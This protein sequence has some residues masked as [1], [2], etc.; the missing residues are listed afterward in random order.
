MKRCFIFFLFFII[1]HST[2]GQVSLGSERVKKLRYSVVRILIDG[3]PVGTGFFVG[4]KAQVL[5]CWHVIELAIKSDTSTKKATLKNLEIELFDSSKYTYGII[6]YY[7][8]DGLKESQ[9][10]D[11]CLLGPLNGKVKP[12]KFQTIPLGSFSDIN[13]GDIVYTCGFP[14]G[15]Q[16]QF[17]STGI[18]SNKWVQP[19][20]YTSKDSKDTVFRNVAWLDLTINKGNSGGPIIKLGSKPE[21][22]RVI[23]IASFIITPSSSELN[24]LANIASMMKKF[25]DF[26]MSMS[27]NG[28]SY[29]LGQAE[30]FE[31]IAR[32]LSA[33]SVGISACTSIDHYLR[34]VSKK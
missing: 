4:E 2:I 3:I 29:S 19:V 21:E 1:T 24:N 10:F 22:D 17:I 16:Q 15:M 25:G 26:G 6:P 9:I 12:K 5:T 13:D 23:G 28:E 33:N 18:V 27:Q 14:L 32:A 31:L 8:K 30:S 7:W 20:Y 11:Y 34:T